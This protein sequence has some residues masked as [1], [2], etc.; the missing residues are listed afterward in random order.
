MHFGR[1]DRKAS[2]IDA[3][4]PQQGPLGRET[5][6][7]RNET[8][9]GSAEDFNH[10]Q[11]MGKQFIGL[12]PPV[13]EI[14]RDDERRRW[15][16][17]AFEVSGERVHLLAPRAG[18]QGEMDADTMKRGGHPWQMKGAME[19]SPPLEPQLSDILIVRV[20]DRKA[21]KDRVAMVPVPVHHVAAI[22]GGRPDIFCQEF[23]LGLEGPIFEFLGIP[24]VSALDLLK[25]HNVWIQ[26]PQSPPQLMH[27]QVLMELRKSLVD[28]VG[29]DVKVRR[30]HGTHGCLPIPLIAHE[31]AAWAKA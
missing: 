13:I 9:K 10:P 18:E 16:G 14:T 1:F 31:W 28:V 15:V 24:A 8:A 27:H 7:G 19:Q 22:G 29:D 3:I 21:G 17:K 25:K 2:H 30:L 4:Q 12:V 11:A 5:P 6:P 20:L 23:V 26:V